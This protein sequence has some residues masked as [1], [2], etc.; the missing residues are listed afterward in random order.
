MCSAHLTFVNLRNVLKSEGTSKPF[1]TVTRMLRSDDNTLR[2]KI[3]IFVYLGTICIRLHYQHTLRNSDFF[4]FTKCVRIRISNRGKWA[5][6]HITVSAELFWTK[7]KSNR[8]TKLYTI[9][10]KQ[11]NASL[12]QCRYTVTYT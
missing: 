5:G 12:N 7:N 11:K 9:V 10:E 3:L 6:S 2:V 4:P 1:Q 8:L